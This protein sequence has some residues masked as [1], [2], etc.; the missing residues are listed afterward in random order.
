M[1][2]HHFILN[3]AY[4]VRMVHDI[5]NVALMIVVLASTYN[6]ELTFR[7][8]GSLFMLRNYCFGLLIIQ[9]GSYTILGMFT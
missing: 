1:N 9:V 4:G 6:E 2:T 8:M 7:G 3:V 5:R